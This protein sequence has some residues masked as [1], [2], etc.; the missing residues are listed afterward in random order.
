MNPTT[1]E[2]EVRG[3]DDA[4]FRLQAVR[5][6]LANREPLHAKMATTATQFTRD[7]LISDTDHKTAQRL[8]ATPTGFRAKNARALQPDWNEESAIIRIPRSTGL[9]R[10]FGDVVIEPKSGRKY[11]TI[12][13]HA[14]T[15]GR[16]VRDFPEGTFAFAIYQG[17]RPSPA[18][19]F[20]DDSGRHKK[21]EVGYWLRKK[22]VQKQDRTLLPFEEDYREISRQAIVAY[23]ANLVYNAPS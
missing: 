17:A 5:R 11:L 19:V 12:P 3:I 10:A 20:A 2:I 13:D 1:L 4:E 9:A 16:A 23:I 7:Y 14:E 8:G 15:Y 6:A 18:L 22:V 21:G